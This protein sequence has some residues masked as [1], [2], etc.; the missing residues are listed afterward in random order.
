MQKKAYE[1]RC[2]SLGFPNE[3]AVK[4]EENA[5]SQKSLEKLRGKARVAKL[6]AVD[7]GRHGV[8][9]CGH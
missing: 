5:G 3:K 7:K 1:L 6:F 9:A 2:K 4:G 8:R